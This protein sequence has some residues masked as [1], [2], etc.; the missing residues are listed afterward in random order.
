MKTSLS[1]AVLIERPMFPRLDTGEV[2]ETDADGRYQIEYPCGCVQHCRRETTGRLAGIS[3]GDTRL[4]LCEA[5]TRRCT[6]C[7]LQTWPH[8]DCDCRAVPLGQAES[9]GPQ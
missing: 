7:G 8:M 3:H 4:E 9:A 1:G 6:E 2:S 5:H